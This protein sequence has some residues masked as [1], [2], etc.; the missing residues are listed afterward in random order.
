M[1]MASLRWWI[2]A[3]MPG[4]YGELCTMSME[5]LRVR[6]NELTGLDVQRSDVMDE[7]AARWWEA[8]KKLDAQ[9]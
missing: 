6:L 8:L 1:S 7:S 5:Q 9:E 2:R 4:L 3:N